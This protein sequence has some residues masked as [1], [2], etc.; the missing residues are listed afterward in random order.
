LGFS[1]KIPG[2]APGILLLDF[3]SLPIPPET[4]R[5]ALRPRVDREFALV[6][7]LIFNPSVSLRMRYPY[8]PL[9]MYHIAGLSVNWPRALLEKSFKI[10]GKSRLYFQKSPYRAL[11]KGPGLFLEIIAKIFTLL[12]LYYP[13]QALSTGNRPR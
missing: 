13:H 12:K 1:K 9:K 11:I 10:K 7:P 4:G 5:T 6:D 3:G 8:F 2:K